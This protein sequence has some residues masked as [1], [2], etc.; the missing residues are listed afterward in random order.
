MSFKFVWLSVFLVNSLLI[1]PSLARQENATEA[2]QKEVELPE[3]KMIE[4]EIK[5]V[6]PDGHPV[7]NADIYC[8]GLRTRANP[9]SH[10]GWGKQQ[11][12]KTNEAGIAKVCFPK[13]AEEKLE[14]GRVTW[15]VEHD[16]FMTFRGDVMVD[17]ESPEIQ[18]TRGCRIALNAVDSETGH[19]ITSD[20]Y[21][22]MGLSDSIRKWK[23][24]SKGM[25]VSPVFSP[26]RIVFRVVHLGKDKPSAFS[27]LI[28]VE[29][30][31]RSSVLLKDVKIHPGVRVEG[32]ID[33]AVPRPI[34]DGVVQA[35]FVNNPNEDRDGPKAWVG[36][37][38]W[39]D[40]AK[41]SED[42]TFVFESVPRD[43]II[44][45][46]VRCDG[47]S[48]ARPEKEAVLKQFP[49]FERKYNLGWRLPFFE[50]LKGQKTTLTVPMRKNSEVNLTVTD[51]N[52][53]PLADS[54]VFIYLQQ[55]LFD[56]GGM[57]YSRAMVTRKF[58]LEPIEN[59]GQHVLNNHPSLT[60]TDDQGKA[61][62]LVPPSKNATL[63]VNAKGY[64][65]EI[66]RNSRSLRF[67]LEDGKSK[68]ITVEM[69]T[70]DSPK[71]GEAPRDN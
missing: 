68:D 19:K 51:P 62:L 50:Q 8:S 71:M 64:Q 3:P 59:P 5:V 34:K 52:G 18:L 46:F 29:P 47:W 54:T 49:H 32:K 48:N 60:K 35:G 21:A 53:K 65:M 63:N 26:A 24:S 12:Y 41:V 70:M 25:L 39:C 22:V 30:E 37:W 7:A 14:V 13:F 20:L 11:R 10:Y 16:D 1:E 45:M 56:G 28:V 67:D 31:G 55:L 38:E 6:D 69:T 66:N 23:L 58:L 36:R 17:N 2:K 4:D 40:I 42:G 44:Q 33:E 15:S 27:D 61:T 57:P 9:A 43:E